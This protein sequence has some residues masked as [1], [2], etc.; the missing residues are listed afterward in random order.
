[1]LAIV[2][3]CIPFLNCAQALR[4]P[5]EISDIRQAKKP[6]NV[7]SLRDLIGQI[8]FYSSSVYVLMNIQLFPFAGI[9]SYSF[10][11]STGRG[12]RAKPR[13]AVA[14]IPV[15]VSDSKAFL[16]SAPYMPQRLG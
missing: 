10:F 14:I 7:Q 8:R 3:A 11:Y 13:P 12:T 9:T 15:L 2:V 6:V 4:V 16:I 5:S 1:M